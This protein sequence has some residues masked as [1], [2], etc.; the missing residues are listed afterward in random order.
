M[1]HKT[2]CGCNGHLRLTSG[3]KQEHLL[4]KG[5][6]PLPR[7]CRGGAAPC[8]PWF[9][10]DYLPVFQKF[11]TWSRRSARGERHLSGRLAGC[12]GRHQ[13]RPGGMG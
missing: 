5:A 1:T 9:E 11:I 6:A 13:R 12:R 2:E 4:L 10:G 8:L 3:C 7:G